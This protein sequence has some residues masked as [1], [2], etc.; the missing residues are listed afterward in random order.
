MYR[1]INFLLIFI[2]LA[3]FNIVHASNHGRC[4]ALSNAGWS[5]KQIDVIYHSYEYGRDFGLS[6]SLAAIS[7]RESSGGVNLVNYSE[8]KFPSAGAHGIMTYK[9]LDFFHLDRENPENVKLAV[10]ML[11]SNINLSLAFSVKE[12]QYW[13]SRW[14]NNWRK[15]WMSYNA[16]NKWWVAKTYVESINENVKL[17]KKCNWG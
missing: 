8:P 13:K 10:E 16:G 12:L 1:T 4:D 5:Q 7:M 3:T 6:Y 17:V 9:V 2:I 15:I 14:G 11:K